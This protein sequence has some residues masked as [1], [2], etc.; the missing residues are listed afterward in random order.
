MIHGGGVDG[1]EK[2]TCRRYVG[3]IMEKLIRNHE[4]GLSLA[5]RRRGRGEERKMGKEAYC[6]LYDDVLRVCE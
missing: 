1:W 5:V 4:G 6:Y 2:K 3:V